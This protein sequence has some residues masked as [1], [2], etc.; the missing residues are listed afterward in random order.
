V[1]AAAAGLVALQAGQ[2]D[3]T[4]AGRCRAGLFDCSLPAWPAGAWNDLR[5]WPVLLGGLVMLPL[6][7]ELPLLVVWCRA[8]AVP[9]SLTILLH[10]AAM[11]GPALVLREPI[12]RWP[13]PVL[14]A[15]VAACLGAGAPAMVWA[16]APW[17]L[18]GV[19]VLQGAA[20]GLAWVGQLWA[21]ARRGR[22]GASPWRAALG[23][24]V[25]T[26]AFG[27][28]VERFGAAG[29]T[30]THGLL[31]AVAVAAWVL[32]AFG[33]HAPPTPAPTET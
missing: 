29:V 9:P 18:L 2:R 8:Q 16:P 1:L 3:G 22:Q 15:V 23:Y 7:A 20:W 24:A 5:Q 6:M 13:A 31:G 12:A 21:P 32:G 26:I 25:L 17:N 30:A 19:A 28:V 27:A 4:P 14:A 10:L 33:H 11:F